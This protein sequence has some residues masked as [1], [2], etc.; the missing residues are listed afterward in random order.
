MR[1]V[2]DYVRE[3][4]QQIYQFERPEELARAGIEVVSGAARFLD[5][6]TVEAG[7]TT[8]SRQ[9]HSS[10]PQGPIRQ[11]RQSPD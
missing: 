5:A 11:Y 2:R 4:I 3:A 8:A 6:H 10:S 9:S 7:R 1:R